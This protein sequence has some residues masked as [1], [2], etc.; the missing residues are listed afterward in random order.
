MFLYT[1]TSLLMTVV[2]FFKFMQSLIIFYNYLI[3]I[4]IDK[5]HNFWA[6]VQFFEFRV[7][8]TLLLNTFMVY[9][10]KFDYL[11]HAIKFSQLSV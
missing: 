2:H 11:L 9:M 8:I 5:F 10:N 4:L 7:P 1:N 3:L 6:I